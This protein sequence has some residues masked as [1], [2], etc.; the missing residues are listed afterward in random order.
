MAKL[1]TSPRVA[2]S[3]PLLQ[4]E[5]RDHASQVNQVSEGRISAVYNAAPAA[6][7]TG[8]WAQGDFVRNSAPTEMGTAPNRYVIFGWLHTGAGFVEC[9]F[10]TGA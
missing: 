10:L 7:T 6:P 4:R 1:N 3:D 8:Q 5:L 9:R 2:L